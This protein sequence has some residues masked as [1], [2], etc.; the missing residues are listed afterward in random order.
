MATQSR[1]PN[2]GIADA[3]G[4]R[5]HGEATGTSLCIDLGTIPGGIHA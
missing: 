5:R 4:D 3:G 2:A 1:C